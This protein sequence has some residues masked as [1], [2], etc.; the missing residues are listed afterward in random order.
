[1]QVAQRSRR[2]CAGRAVALALTWLG[3]LPVLGAGHSESNADEAFSYRRLWARTRFS[4]SIA[5]ALDEHPSA[6]RGDARERVLFDAL[7]TFVEDLPAE[8][9]DGPFDARRGLFE[10]LDDLVDRLVETFG[11][12]GLAEWPELAALSG[13]ALALTDGLGAAAVPPDLQAPLARAQVEWRLRQRWTVPVADLA[14]T[15]KRIDECARILASE[16][17]RAAFQDGGPQVRRQL[18]AWVDAALASPGW[19]LGQASASRAEARS[20]QRRERLELL[21][22]GGPT[23]AGIEALVDRLRED[24]ATSAGV[25]VD[26]GSSASATS[27]DPI[28]P[29]NSGQPDTRELALR[30]LEA[31]GLVRTLA[32]NLD[33]V[34]PAPLSRERFLEICDVFDAFPKLM[35]ST[36]DAAE[37]AAIAPDGWQQRIAASETARIDVASALPHDVDARLLDTEGRTYVID[38][39]IVDPLGSWSTV[40]GVDLL[41]QL[42]SVELGVPVALHA[43]TIEGSFELP[44]EFPLGVVAFLGPPAEDGSI[45]EWTVL[46]ADA[47]SRAQLVSL[48]MEMTGGNYITPPRPDTHPTV[49]EPV[50]RFLVDFLGDPKDIDLRTHDGREQ[51]LRALNRPDETAVLVGATAAQLVELLAKFRATTQLPSAA[52]C[53]WIEPWA[54]RAFGWAQ[55]HTD[56]RHLRSDELVDP[57]RSYILREAYHLVLP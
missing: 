12:N 39:L 15:T 32:Q 55:L 33:R 19:A 47:W 9:P 57:D 11:E 14:T 18:G 36:A 37:W 28:D 6:A 50:Y 2:R 54:A 46:E 22:R 29:T 23:A 48:V 13:R 56:V 16:A 34:A 45:P 44:P 1:M 26:G 42:G 43:D 38:S 51:A 17:G 27:A 21:F 10:A 41:L 7:A 25:S 24:L 52:V 5:A 35:L 3:L 20:K 53:D 4:L 40:P 49:W 8:V 30:F 31:R